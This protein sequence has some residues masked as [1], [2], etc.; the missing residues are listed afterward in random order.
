M[1]HAGTWPVTVFLNGDRA[2]LARKS[3]TLSGRNLNQN[4]LADAGI[5]ACASRAGHR[6]PT[7]AALSFKF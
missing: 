4:N 2:H 5:A 1:P 7:L 3:G 6:D